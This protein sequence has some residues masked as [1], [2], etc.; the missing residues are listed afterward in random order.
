MN[1][2]KKHAKRG[3]GNDKM[4]QIRYLS[5]GNRVPVASEEVP[6]ASRRV[7]VASKCVRVA[8]EQVPIGY[9]SPPESSPNVLKLARSR[10]MIEETCSMRVARRVHFRLAWKTWNHRRGPRCQSGCHTVIKKEKERNVHST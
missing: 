5:L 3:S 1:M 4:L 6:V 2:T 7:G 10:P 9:D 8:S